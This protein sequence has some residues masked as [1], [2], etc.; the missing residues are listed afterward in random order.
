[1]TRRQS[2]LAAALAQLAPVP[3]PFAADTI[4]ALASS[5]ER[6]YFDEAVAA[7]MAQRLRKAWADGAYRSTGEPEAL[8]QA[9]TRDLYGWSKDKHL[10]V[11]LV[12]PAAPRPG[13]VRPRRVDFRIPRVEILPSGHGLLTIT[14]FD[15]LTL[16]REAIAA[17]MLLL[18]P[19]TALLVDLRENGGGNPD[20][21]A[22]LLGYFFDKPNLPLFEIA[23]RGATA[24][25]MYRTPAAV[26]SHADANRP[27]FVLTSSRTFSAGEGFAYLLQ[28]RR[29]AQVIG[30]VTAGAANPGR[31]YPLNAQLEVTIPNGQVRSAIRRGNWEGTGV[32]PNIRCAA[33]Q[34]LT[35]AQQQA[36]V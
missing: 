20:T 9:L 6:H 5:I 28:E 12:R 10:V 31:P 1:M 19:A 2:M 21:V 8:A 18:Q 25:V 26:P 3:D 33:L 29:R 32:V 34:A 36:G 7:T 11:S 13:N 15:R 14:G 16:V 4:Q 35:I 30:E 22:F 23:S 27:V 17:A 24:P